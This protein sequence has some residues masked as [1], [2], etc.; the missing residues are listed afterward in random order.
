[1]QLISFGTKPYKRLY[2][3]FADRDVWEDIMGKTIARYTEEIKDH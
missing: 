2:P 1:M 3:G